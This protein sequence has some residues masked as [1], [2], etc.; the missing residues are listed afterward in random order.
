LVAVKNV[1]ESA[2]EAIIEARSQN[3]FSSLFEFCEYVDLRR[4]NKRVVES[5]IKCGAFDSTGA[6]RS[7]M[8]ACRFE[9]SQ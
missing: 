8:L 2:I 7:Q 6:K 1:G 3:K 5:L 4:V 9:K